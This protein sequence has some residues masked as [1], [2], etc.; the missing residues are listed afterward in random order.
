MQFRFFPKLENLKLDNCFF[1]KFL[2]EGLRDTFLELQTVFMISAKIKEKVIKETL[3][4]PFD[5]LNCE[6]HA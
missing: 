2:P 1:L 4:R 6:R 5:M 3:I